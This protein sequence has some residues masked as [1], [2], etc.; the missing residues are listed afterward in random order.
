MLLAVVTC[1]LNN[2]TTK[3]IRNILGVVAATSKND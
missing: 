2:C 3:Y 1:I